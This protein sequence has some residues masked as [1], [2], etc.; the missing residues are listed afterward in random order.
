MVILLYLVHSPHLFLPICRKNLRRTPDSDGSVLGSVA[1]IGGTCTVH[2]AACVN[3]DDGLGAGYIIAHGI[4][5]TYVAFNDLTIKN[6]V[7]CF[8]SGFYP[9]IVF[10][11]LAFYR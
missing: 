2:N 7:K 4:G 3:Q 10:F 11:I 9:K 8:K 5:H 6:F 1:M